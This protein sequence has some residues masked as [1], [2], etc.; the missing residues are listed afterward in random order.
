MLRK[1]S[2]ILFILLA[3]FIN[4]AC[5][6]NQDLCTEITENEAQRICVLLQ[7]NGLNAHKVK[8]GAEDQVTWSVVLETP[9][10][11][12]DKAV[13]EA[14]NILNENDLP[15]SKRD[16]LKE[17]FKEGALIPTPTEEQL[18]KLAAIQESLELSLERI[19]GIVSAQIHVV[20]PNPNPLVEESKQ[21]QPSASVLLKYNTATPPL[22]VAEVRNIIA[23]SIEGLDPTRVQV[24]M[25][26]VAAPNAAQFD[27]L[28]NNMIKYI[29]LGAMAAIAVFAGLFIY[30]YIRMRK[31]AETVS[32]L[33]RERSVALRAKGQPAQAA[34]K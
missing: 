7:R 32:Q 22:D 23:P 4:S 25:K 33:E 17:A 19:T 21:T 10:I 5:N 24:V 2:L 9:Y 34:A 8:V 18:R 13:V 27:N 11:I 12:G 14:L 3:T 16:P 30:S 20:L 1:L 28:K 31:L 6:R 29:G 15:R 26:A